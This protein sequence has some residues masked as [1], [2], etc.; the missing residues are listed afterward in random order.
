MIRRVMVSPEFAGVLRR[1]C[2][3]DPFFYINTFVWTINPKRGYLR[4]KVPFIF[5]IIRSTLFI[6]H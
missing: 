6:R 5:V 2:A 4:K 3:A 1:I